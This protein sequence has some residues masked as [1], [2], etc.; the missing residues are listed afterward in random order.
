MFKQYHYCNIFDS[1]EIGDGTVI[2]SY[3]E[4]GDKTIIGRNCRIG[5]YVFTCAGVVIEDDCFIGPRVTFTNDKYPPSGGNWRGII[6]RKG[7]SIG[8]ASTILPGVEIGRGA[9]VGAGSVVTKDVPPYQ[10]WV[11]NPARELKRG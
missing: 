2:G 4:I 1:A 10:T 8:A 7:A 5:A 11:G 6:V 3:S 9:I